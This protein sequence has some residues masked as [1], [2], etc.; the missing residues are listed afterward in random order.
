[1]VVE[2]IEVVTH[3]PEDKSHTALFPTF[4]IFKDVQLQEEEFLI[5]HAELCSLQ[6]THIGRNVHVNQCLRQ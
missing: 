4:N 1:M 2:V 3:M 5:L 6:V